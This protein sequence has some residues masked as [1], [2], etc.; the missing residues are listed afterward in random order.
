MLID[1]PIGEAPV[2]IDAINFGLPQFGIV[3]QDKAG[4]LLKAYLFQRVQFLGRGVLLHYDETSK[5]V[6]WNEERVTLNSG[7]DI[8][9]IVD[10]NNQFCR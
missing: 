4:D 9:N 6:Y 8:E 2:N 1:I 3:A 10:S 5:T 7:C